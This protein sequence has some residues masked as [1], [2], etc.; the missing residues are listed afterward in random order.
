M[1]LTQEGVWLPS[2]RVD[3]GLNGKTSTAGGGECS[4]IQLIVHSGLIKDSEIARSPLRLNNLYNAAF[5]FKLFYSR[6]ILQLHG[7]PFVTR[8]LYDTNPDITLLVT[9]MM[10]PKVSS[11]IR[12]Y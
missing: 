5:N 6:C 4:I 10:D 9:W 2:T 8:F 12:N 3:K 7:R 11:A 1:S